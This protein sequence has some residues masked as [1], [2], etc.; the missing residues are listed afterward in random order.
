MTRNMIYAAVSGI[1]EKYLSDA[2]NLTRIKS[3]FRRAGRIKISFAAGICAG[4]F[5]L[6][7]VIGAV[8]TRRPEIPLSSHT[9]TE[10][11]QKENR[12][13]FS[14]VPF[15]ASVDPDADA[16]GEDQL[17][18]VSLTVRGVEYHQLKEEDSRLYGLPT[19]IPADELG[20]PAGTVIE[21]FPNREPDGDVSSPEPSLV[22][23][24]VYYYAPTGGKA[25]VIAVKDGLC[26]PF[27]VWTWGADQT[28]REVCAFFGAEASDRGIERISYRIGKTEPG[29]YRVGVERTVSDA[30]TVNGICE[31]LLQLSP[32]KSDG[33]DASATPQW[34]IDAMQ[35]YK[36]DPE[37]FDAED[38]VFTVYFRNGTMLR[39]ILYKPYIGNGYVDN[40]RELTPEQN[41]ELRSMFGEAGG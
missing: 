25:V 3:D 15:P 23:A 21:S 6:A 30:R 14:V 18:E 5:A 11:A 24:E 16:Y 32:E 35:A 4:F 9:P 12:N 22:G 37:R 26:S 2:E 20:E 17:H 36:D 40:M 39:D 19:S 33:A 31:V 41:A 7:C 13:A 34:F 27:A 29:G 28:F 1:D 8:K 10:D 38:I